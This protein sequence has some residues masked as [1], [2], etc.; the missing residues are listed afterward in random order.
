ML[1]GKM[2]YNGIWTLYCHK[3]KINDKR[4]FG[5]TC[6]QP[7]KR[8]MNGHGYSR[9]LSIGRA[10]DKYGWN[11]FEHIIIFK[12]LI[13]SDAKKLE[14]I[15]IA[16]YETQSEKYGYNLTCGGDGVCGF[17]HSDESRHKMSLAKSGENHPNFGKHL[18]PETCHKISEAQKGRSGPTKGIPISESHKQH[19]S[20]AKNKA[21]NAYDDDGNLILSFPSARKAAQA[22]GVNYKNISLCIHGERKRCGGYHWNFA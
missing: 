22:L 14:R 17:R 6:Q 20:E 21:V 16:M 1:I 10:I 18:S 8:W 4:Y 7:E 3:N 12:N 5:I 19:I 15:Y 13:E 2:E 11:N 9:K